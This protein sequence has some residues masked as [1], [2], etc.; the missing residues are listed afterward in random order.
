[1]DKYLSEASR[2]YEKLHN[3][4]KKIKTDFIS[5]SNTIANIGDTLRELYFKF[6][7]FDNKVMEGKVLFLDNIYSQLM[8]N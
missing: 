3:D 6:T 4:T 1:M 7:E 8:S 5:T 2:L